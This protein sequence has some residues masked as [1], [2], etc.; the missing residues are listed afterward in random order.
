MQDANPETLKWAI[1]VGGPLFGLVVIVLF[2]YRYDFR[3]SLD[4]SRAANAVLVELVKANTAALV[5]HAAAVE[6]IARA[7]EDREK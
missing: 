4:E 7:V 2:Y 3:R 6:R 5:A 1:Q